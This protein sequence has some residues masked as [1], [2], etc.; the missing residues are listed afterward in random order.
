MPKEMQ[1]L[2]PWHGA[3]LPQTLRQVL[4]TQVYP[5]WQSRAE[6]QDAPSLPSP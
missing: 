4:P 2:T 1:V 6:T 5:T 3:A